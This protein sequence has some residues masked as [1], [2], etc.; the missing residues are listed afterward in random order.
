M[1][2]AQRTAVMAILLGGVLALGSV[3]VGAQKS[4]QRWTTA[5]TVMPDALVKEL[6]NPD[7]T[8]RPVVVCAGFQVLYRGAH[9]P[10]AAFAGPPSRPQGLAALKAWAAPL[11]R[12]TNLVVYC[13]CCPMTKCPN[14]RPAFA[15]LHAMGF[16]RLRVLVLPRSFAKDWVYRH[17]PIARGTM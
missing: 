17:L 9:V 13:G 1:R 2:K 4:A 14:I 3:T 12:T 8:A 7:R 5:E 11:P 15:A 16:T 10:G 6:K